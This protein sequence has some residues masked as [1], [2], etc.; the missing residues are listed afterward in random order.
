MTALQK[1]SILYVEER[2]SVEYLQLLTLE[3]KKEEN[4][5]VGREKVQEAVVA[6]N[7]TKRDNV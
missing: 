2:L 3:K 7:G 4:N 6:T 1:A 5:S